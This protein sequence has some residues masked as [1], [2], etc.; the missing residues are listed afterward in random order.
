M[1]MEQ[2]SLWG[3]EPFIPQPMEYDRMAHTYR[4]RAVMTMEPG[5]LWEWSR[6]PFIPQPM[7]YDRWKGHIRALFNVLRHGGWVH[8]DRLCAVTKSKNITARISNLRQKG[9]EIECMRLTDEGATMY[10]ITQYLGVS[11]TR[12]GH[13]PT[14]TCGI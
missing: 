3:R 1:T 4:R 12:G 10:R 6:E 8:H 9:Y 7:D 5:S 13:C 2:G 14:C 11:T